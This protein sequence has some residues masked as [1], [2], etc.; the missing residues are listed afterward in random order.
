MFGTA[1]H[2]TRRRN[3]LV[4]MHGYISVIIEECSIGAIEA[5][6]AKQ[7]DN[8]FS[9]NDLEVLAEM[10]HGVDGASVARQSSV[11]TA[12]DMITS[13]NT[14]RSRR[15][16]ALL[17]GFPRLHWAV[18]AVTSASLLVAFLLE[19][20]QTAT[21]FLNSF[22]LRLLFGMVVS[23]GSFASV[24]FADLWDPFQGSFCVTTATAQL[25]QLRDQIA[26]DVRAAE[27]ER[28]DFSVPTLPIAPRLWGESSQPEAKEVDKA[29]AS[30]LVAASMPS[31]APCDGRT[32]IFDAKNTFYFHLLTGPLAAN[33]R[34]LGDIIAWTGGRFFKVIRR[35]FTTLLIWPRCRQQGPPQKE[36]PIAIRA[37]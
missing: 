20:N 1:Q 37:T 4:L 30:S 7:P 5:I 17:S 8:N 15:L 25:E 13:L 35:T 12:T 34:A 22:Q 18:L 29:S 10:L 11:G 27:A 9:G 24:L 32:P 14:H 3:A 19:S 36:A 31:S 21:Q 33:V 2:A 28:E 16:A 6:E 26:L 23:V